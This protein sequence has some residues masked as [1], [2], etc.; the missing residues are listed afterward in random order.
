MTKVKHLVVGFGEVGKAIH[1]I[2]GGEAQ[3]IAK[4]FDFNGKCEVMHV[5]FPYFKGF[6][7]E[8][9]MYQKRYK[10][11][12]TIIHSTVPLGTSLKCNAVHSPIRGVH[13]ELEKG[14]RTFVKYFGGKGAKKAAKIFSDL[15]ITTSVVPDSRTTEALKL[16]DTTIYGSLILLNKEI[17][18]WCDKNGVDFNIIYTDASKTYNEGY[19]KL[20]RSEVMRPYLNYTK[21]KIGG[22]CVVPN[23]KLLKSK[24]AYDILSYE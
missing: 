9:K 21:G 18:H 20:G 2:V 19:L 22:H 1:A 24:S 17:K 10:P 23:A 12:L 14:I 15:G 11:Q 16:W 7:K 13:P 8:V 4:E 6:V 3:D 5:C